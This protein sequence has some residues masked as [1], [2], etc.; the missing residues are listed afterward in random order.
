MRGPGARGAATSM[1]PERLGN[2]L[3]EA[4]SA[5]PVGGQQVGFIYGLHASRNQTGWNALILTS[6]G[7]EHKTISAIRLPLCGSP[8]RTSAWA[9]KTT[10][11]CTMDDSVPGRQRLSGDIG[12]EEVYIRG[13]AVGGDD[14]PSGMRFFR[15]SDPVRGTGGGGNPVAGRHRRFARRPA[16]QTTHGAGRASGGMGNEG[17]DP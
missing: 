15:R 9:E 5:S 10:Y 11:I 3:I 2:D 4:P 1:P 17:P 12:Y 6:A 14:G 16:G 7:T 8:C 13:D